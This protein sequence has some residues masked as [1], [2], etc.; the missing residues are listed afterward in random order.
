MS[1]ANISS[2]Q[3]QNETILCCDV[4]KNPLL[5]MEV[6]GESSFSFRSM[7]NAS[8]WFVL[9][10]YIILLSGCS[11]HPLTISISLICPNLFKIKCKFLEVAVLART[12][13][14]FKFL[15]VTTTEGMEKAADM[16]DLFC[17]LVRNIVKLITKFWMIL[18]FC[19][20]CYESSVCSLLC[21][22]LMTYLGH[23]VPKSSNSLPW[24]ITIQDLD[25]SNES[26]LTL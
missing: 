20:Q 5:L 22:S 6:A 19:S 25:A 8:H 21:L 14:S 23:P 15:D 7:K 24:W 4:C 18:V 17:S 13:T 9:V 11:T 12:T 3:C 16:R 2:S 1:Q 10:S 26:Y